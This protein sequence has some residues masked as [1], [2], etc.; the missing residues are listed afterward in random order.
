MP[1]KVEYVDA[2]SHEKHFSKRCLLNICQC[3]FN[4]KK[5]NMIVECVYEHPNINYWIS[6]LLIINYVI[7]LKKK[8]KLFLLS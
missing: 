5:S 4:S 1:Y 7:R 2:L 3:P 6:I 8:Q